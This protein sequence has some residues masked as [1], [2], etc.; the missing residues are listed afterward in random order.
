M[1]KCKTILCPRG[2]I[3]FC[4]KRLVGGRCH[5]ERMEGRSVEISWKD[6]TVTLRMMK[7]LDEEL[8]KGS[9]DWGAG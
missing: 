2:I 9:W 3:Y 6:T 5:E 7:A 8:G 1:L 4:K